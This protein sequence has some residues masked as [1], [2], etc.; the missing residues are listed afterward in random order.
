MKFYA[1]LISCLFSASVW[2]AEIVKVGVY[3]FPPYAFITDKTAGITFEMIAAMNTFQKDYEF[4]AVPTTAKRRYR[5]FEQK[6][7]PCKKSTK[8]TSSPADFFRHQTW[9][10]FF[11]GHHGHM[12]TKNV[13]KMYMGDIAVTSRVC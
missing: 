11:M 6:Y 10:I 3:D 9:D 7:P 4:V 1:L 5:D 8:N 13:Q 12:C 2:A